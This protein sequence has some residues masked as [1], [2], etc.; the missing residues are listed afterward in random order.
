M[1]MRT[2]AP[3]RLQA[4]NRHEIRSSMMQEE[5]VANE[6]LLSITVPTYNVGRDCLEKNIRSVAECAAAPFVEILVIDDGSTDGTG[7]VA[8]ELHARYPSIVR[9]MHK[10]NGGYGSAVN[11][12]VSIAQGKYFCV[13]DADDYVIS[14]AFSKFVFRLRD[15]DVDLVLNDY[16]T[17]NPCGRV[18]EV[19]KQSSG[20]PV[21]TSFLLEE[22]FREFD[23]FKSAGIGVHTECMRTSL[24]KGIGLE[25][26]EKHFYV[27]REYTMY[28][29]PQLETACYI[30][31]VTRC[32][33]LGRSGQSADRA[34]QLRNYQ[35]AIDVTGYLH[36]FYREHASQF[37]E[38]PNMA[39]TFLKMA[40]HHDRMC[41][42]MQLS[43]ADARQAKRLIREHDEW[44]K[45]SW[46]ELYHAN[47]YLPVT[48][49]RKSGFALFGP[50]AL[51][52]KLMF[53]R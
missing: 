18:L 43:N 6:T 14:D 12:G 32:Y 50:A 11:M 3:H 17:V 36:R 34:T 46:P 52:Y 9:V 31:L 48:L 28:P 25:C 40:A 22:H 41:Y 5:Q 39:Y 7:R 27:D 29:F 24:L 37:D 21:G 49:F 8:D 4:K 30:D 23:P 19:I 20:L 1:G 10:E 35:Q 2:D 33:L 53:I 13:I 38:R 44:V 47:P 45:G 15:L 16:Q 51:L 42:A 26:H